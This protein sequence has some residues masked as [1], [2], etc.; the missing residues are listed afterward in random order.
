MSASDDRRRAI[1]RR[2]R[3]RDAVGRALDLID[4][5]QGDD[6]KAV[7][8]ALATKDLHVVALVLAQLADDGRPVGDL[9]ERTARLVRLSR[10]TAFRDPDDLMPCGTHSAYNRHLAR[11]EQ[12]CAECK[13][14]ERVY[15]RNRKR[16][17]RA[18]A[19]QGRAA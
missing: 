8:A 10:D 1:R 19:R 5:V 17:V 14:A 16:R 18:E 7:D 6:G 9:Y 13:A 4:A 11:N 3:T 2:E 12:P 15:S